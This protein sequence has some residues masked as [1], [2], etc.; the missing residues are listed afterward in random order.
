MIGGSAPKYEWRANADD[1]TRSIV[2]ACRMYELEEMRKA[3]GEKGATIERWLAEAHPDN[4]GNFS[5]AGV[6]IRRL[7]G[8]Q[9]ERRCVMVGELIE[10]YRE[11]AV[12]GYQVMMDC[13]HMLDPQRPD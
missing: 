3:F 2:E 5:S 10:M 6:G 13:L 8:E 7:I 1:E 12:T 4:E 11:G 9:N